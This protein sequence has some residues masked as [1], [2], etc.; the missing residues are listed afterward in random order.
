MTNSETQ[1]IK[2]IALEYLDFMKET[3]QL[4][5]DAKRATALSLRKLLKLKDGDFIL[6]NDDGSLE[7]ELGE[8][9]EA[10]EMVMSEENDSKTDKI[11]LNGKEVTET[12]FNRQREAV[13]KQKGA[14]LEEVS[15]GKFRLHLND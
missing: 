11:V 5:D 13:E 15:K 6:I 4:I 12:E 2:K 1:L 10:K 9:S 3:R 14:R 7:I 8:L